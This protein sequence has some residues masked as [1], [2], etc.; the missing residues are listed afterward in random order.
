[1]LPFERV[2]RIERCV[3]HAGDDFELLFENVEA[4]SKCGKRNAV[5]GVF[6][7]EP[8][9]TETKFDTT[10]THVIDLRDGYCKLARQTEC[11][12]SDECAE[13]NRAGLARDCTES[14][15]RIGG[16]RKGITGPHAQVMVGTEK[17]VESELLGKL[18]NRE[19]LAVR[20]AL[21]GLNKDAKFHGPRLPV[22]GAS[23]AEQGDEHDKRNHEAEDDANAGG[24][25]I[26]DP[27]GDV[28]IQAEHPAGD[29]AA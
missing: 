15:P 21:L 22:V 6:G 3:P 18:R 11:C 17:G 13:T 24:P 4:L 10:V 27:L 12:R 2:L 28:S 19:L 23:F 1:M 16:A 14:D 7:I 29:A 20:S 5:R 9:S 25:D 8:A 26:V